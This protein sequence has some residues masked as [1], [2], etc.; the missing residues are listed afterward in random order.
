MGLFDTFVAP[1]PTCK[2]QTETQTKLFDCHLRVIKPEDPV[3]VESPD[4][5]Q[6]LVQNFQAKT[7]CHL[8]HNP[9]TVQIENGKFKG[10]TTATP[11]GVESSFGDFRYLT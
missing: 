7:P 11:E 9:M 2:Q 4:Y 3:S 1:C 6:S 10:F 8:C 5:F